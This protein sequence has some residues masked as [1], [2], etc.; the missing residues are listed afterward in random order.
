M[1][2][3]LLQLKGIEKSFPGV[4]ALLP[5]DL[6]MTEGEVLG[7]VGENGAGKSTLIKILSGVYRADAG[8]VIW[9][10]RSVHFGSPRAALEAGIATIHQELADAA[11]LTIGE[12]LLLGES[13]P[14]RRWGGVDW[15][16][17]HEDATRRLRALDIELSSTRL[18]ATLTAAER[19]EVAIARALSRKS[20]LLILDEP[21]ASLSDHEVEHLLVRLRAL[22]AKGVAVIYVS[23]R[24][25]E[26]LE[27]TDRVVVL[28]D[29]ELVSTSK[30]SDVDAGDLIRAM[31]GR[32]LEQIY[33]RARGESVGDVALE[34]DGATRD[35][36]F[37]DISFQVRAGEIVGLGGL[38]GA[39]RSEIARAIFGLYPLDA[40]R[41]R[42]RGEAW[43]PSGPH[44]SMRAGLV[45]LPEERKR[46]ALVLEHG[47]DVSLRI[48]F[49]DLLARCGLVPRRTS[50]DR[51]SA[52][53]S[54]YGIRATGPSQLV[55]TLSGGNQQKTVFARWL[56]RRPEV[57]ILD[58]PTR[59]VDVGAKAEI[60]ETIDRLAADGKAIVLVSSELPELLGM[61]DRVLVLR[62]G[63]IVAELSGRSATQEQVLLAAS[64]LSP[65][66]AHGEASS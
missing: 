16:R 34:L 51:V 32:P 30:T 66:A 56:E 12:N 58:E 19:Q 26:I 53:I 42:L 25:D 36:M 6:E 24:L 44:E 17:L 37:H 20:R 21:T 57:L 64:G 5:L 45:Y 54:R 43:Q 47:L 63:R 2:T 10:G 33:P 60:H 38:V 14:R 62:E 28:R 7:L 9:E 1:P 27:L 23:H 18:F 22:R 40:G 41:M 61:S 49:S 13:W 52:A 4:R 50:R 39:G 48:G 3:P 15:R 59:G 8:D 55:G 11:R 35:G 29:G 46:Q 31:V 65:E